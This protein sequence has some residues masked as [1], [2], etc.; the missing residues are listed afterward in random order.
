MTYLDNPCNGKGSCGKCKIRLV[1]G[2]LPEI[3]DT[4]L[5]F[6]KTDE[7]ASG[8]RLF[9]L[10]NPQEDIVIEMLQKERKHKI[11]TTGYIP[12]F[13]FK[14]S[15]HK[16]VFELENPHLEIKFPSKIRYAAPLDSKI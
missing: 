4:E 15:I 8:I 2:N 12:D 9:C 7:L 6:L 13:D 16:K 3:S 14:P 10:V 11:L 5:K 1:G